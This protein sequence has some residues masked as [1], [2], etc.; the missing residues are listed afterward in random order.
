VT[1]VQGYAKG[2]SFGGHFV[3]VTAGPLGFPMAFL[4]AFDVSDPR[5]PRQ[6]G[7]IELADYPEAVFVRDTLAFVA[8]RTEGLRIISVSRPESLAERGF[9]DTPGTATDVLVTDGYALVADADSGVRIPPR[10]WRLCRRPAPRSVS[11]SLSIDS[12]LPLGMQG[13]L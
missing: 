10:R 7:S 6:V 11:A 3:F 2:I 5:S 12:L 13:W 9:L 1:E 4:H 8:D